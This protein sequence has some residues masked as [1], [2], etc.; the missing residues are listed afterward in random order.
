MQLPGWCDIFQLTPSQVRYLR[1]AWYMRS[2]LNRRSGGAYIARYSPRLTGCASSRKKHRVG[3]VGAGMAGLYAAH[4]LQQQKGDSEIEFHLYEMAGQAGGRVYTHHFTSEENQYYEAGAMRIPKTYMHKPVMDLIESLNDT[5]HAKLKVIKYNLSHPG[6][7]VFV[8]G[9]LAP[10]TDAEQTAEGLGFEV[11]VEYRNQTAH[12]LLRNGWKTILKYDKSSFR[13]YLKKKGWDDSVIGF[14]E[15]MCS[16]TNQFTLSFPEMI[17]QNLDFET[18]SD[19]WQTLDGGMDTLPQGL[20]GVVGLK[21][22]TFG[23]RVQAI[24]DVDGK[25]LIRAETAG[26]RVEELF[27]KVILA[28]PPSAVRMIPK[29]P[30]WSSPKE[31]AILSIYFEPLYKMGLRF[32]TRFWE[33]VST[34]SWAGQSTTDLPIRWIV[35]PSYGINTEGPGVL[36]IYSWMTDAS[37]WSSVKFDDRVRCALHHLVEVYKDEDVDVYDL[38][39]AANDMP[40][41]EHNPTGDCMLLPGQFT[42]YFEIAQESEGN[43]YFASEHLSRHHTW[44]T[45]ALDSARTTAYHVFKDLQPEEL[46]ST[47]HNRWIPQSGGPPQEDY[48][49]ELERTTVIREALK[50]LSADPGILETTFSLHCSGLT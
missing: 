38:F 19:M 34:S 36:L 18:P 8:N 30:R 41:A 45:G 11:P 9:R 23:A 10:M 29:R 6:N 25:V 49:S 2:S 5:Y 50:H 3:I 46:S 43:I 32:K 39:M 12:T 31:E 37:V 16:E 33:K 20:A 4:W 26:R 28:I 14:V 44:I 7:I 27:N 22:I 24:E 15:T 13:S 42:K 40:L 48:D 47:I 1:D 21:N 35:Y 17:M